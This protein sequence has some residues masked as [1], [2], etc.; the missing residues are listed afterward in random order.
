MSE[1]FSGRVEKTWLSPTV[2][3]HTGPSVAV[4]VVQARPFG[5]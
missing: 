5:R 1:H 2:G 3:I 4:G